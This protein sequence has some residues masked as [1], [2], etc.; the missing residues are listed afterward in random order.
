MMPIA[1]LNV[2]RPTGVVVTKLDEATTFGCL[3]NISQKSKLPLCYFTQ[4]QRVP[5]DIEIAT[6]ERVVDLVLDL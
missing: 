6:P 1:R 2:F 4:G 5:E 3:Y